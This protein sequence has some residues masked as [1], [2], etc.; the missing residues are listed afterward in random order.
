M[1]MPT[2]KQENYFLSKPHQPFFILGITNA[3]LFMLFFALSY[4]GILSFVIDIKTYHV[5]SLIFLVFSNVFTGFLF[6][7]FPR[8]NQTAVIKKSYYI[9]VFYTALLGSLVFLVGSFF[10]FYAVVAGMLITFVAQFF[11]VKQLHSIYNNAQALD[12]TDSFWILNANYFGLFGH[13]FFIL[14]LFVPVALNA[15]VNISFYLYLIFLAFSVAQRMIPF[16]S[17]SFAPKNE[18]FIKIVFILFI[19]KAFFA[20]TD[21]KIA[22]II[23]DLILGVY[24]AKEFLRWELKPFESPAILWVLHLALFWLPTAFLLSAFSLSAELF[25]YLLLLS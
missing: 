11:I 1:I 15:A 18:R 24:L 25:G 5:Y 14:S 21:M 10:N 16:F 23:I 22:E 3:I 13:A 4:K 2:K 7:T 12:K 6:T 19:E 17:H 8:F 9:N 20:S